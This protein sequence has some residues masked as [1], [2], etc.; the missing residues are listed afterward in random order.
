MLIDSVGRT[1]NLAEIASI[2]PIWERMGLP[3]KDLKLPSKISILKKPTLLRSEIH[4]V[5]NSSPPPPPKLQNDLFDD[6]KKRSVEFMNRC[7]AQMKAIHATQDYPNNRPM[8]IRCNSNINGGS[9]CHFSTFTAALMSAVKCAVPTMLISPMSIGDDPIASFL[10]LHKRK[11]TPE[12]AG[13]I[14]LFND[15]LL[16]SFGSSIGM[17]I[18]PFATLISYMKSFVRH[19]ASDSLLYVARQLLWWKGYG[20]RPKY[21]VSS[22]AYPHFGSPYRWLKILQDYPSEEERLARLCDFQMTLKERKC[23]VHGDLPK[24]KSHCNHILLRKNKPSLDE[25][26]REHFAAWEDGVPGDCGNKEDL[27]DTSEVQVLSC[28]NLVKARIRVKT[29]PIIL[30]IHVEL[31]NKEIIRS[32]SEKIRMGSTI[33]QLTGI[34]FHLPGH[35]VT[36]SKDRSDWWTLWDDLKPKVLE[37]RYRYSEA[38]RNMKM[39]PICFFYVQLPK[40]E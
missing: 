12:T 5:R 4:P 37:E 21:T 34:I 13:S 28:M 32:W 9:P 33:Y 26:L 23:A 24:Q 20:H 14:P 29:W 18:D 2:D 17:C 1:G 38:L 6:Y 27:D 22:N 35:F 36:W 11:T 3:K 8:L 19:G 15:M 25:S 16:D 39:K 30:I 40:E 10:A 31:T 7:G